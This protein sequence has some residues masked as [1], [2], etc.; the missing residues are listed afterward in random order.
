MNYCLF[1]PPTTPNSA[2][3]RCQGDFSTTA[4]RTCKPHIFSCLHLICLWLHNPIVAS[5]WTGRTYGVWCPMRFLGKFLANPL[6]KGWN[7]KKFCDSSIQKN[8]CAKGLFGT[9][10]KLTRDWWLEARVKDMANWEI[11]ERI[12]GEVCCACCWTKPTLPMWT[13]VQ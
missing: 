6:R 3:P 12:G 9:D 8:V 10:E 4:R 1:D 2:S 7:R 13:P 11:R 5:V